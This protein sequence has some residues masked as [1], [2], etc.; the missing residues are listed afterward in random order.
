[1]NTG[2]WRGVGRSPAKAAAYRVFVKAL[3][4]K[5]LVRPAQCEDC[6]KGCTPNGHHD[7]YDQPLVVRWLCAKCHMQL[8]A[9]LA[10]EQPELWGDRR[11]RRAA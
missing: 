9:R 11:T 4:D 5:R 1:M 10:K 6:G 8:H 7:D 3:K 2:Y